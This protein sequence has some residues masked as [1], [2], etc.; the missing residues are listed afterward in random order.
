MSPLAIT[1]LNSAFK[2]S[3]GLLKLGIGSMAIITCFLYFPEKSLYFEP[4]FSSP[5]A[6]G[7]SMVSW[8]F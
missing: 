3:S 7:K 1:V 2:K 4:G 5:G 6:L 8:N